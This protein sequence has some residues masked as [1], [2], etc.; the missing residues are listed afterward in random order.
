MKNKATFLVLNRCG[1]KNG[2]I[3]M[4]NQFLTSKR[5]PLF[6]YVLGYRYMGF[7]NQTKFIKNMYKQEIKKQF[8]IEVKLKYEIFKFSD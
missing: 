2:M 7:S 6:P 8:N 4:I 3:N 1:R 5:F